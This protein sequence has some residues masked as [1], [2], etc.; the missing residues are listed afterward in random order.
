MSTR[1]LQRRLANVGV[2]YSD[3]VKRTRE[4]L[5]T[6]WLA[7][8]AIPVSEIAASLGYRDPTNFTRA[9]LR[10]ACVSPQQYRERMNNIS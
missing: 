4:R 3:I 2:S 5:A 10:K 9:F 6:Q 8:T 7:D 1:T